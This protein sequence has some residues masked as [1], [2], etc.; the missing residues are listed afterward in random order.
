MARS[1]A[2]AELPP[3]LQGEHP[4]GIRVRAL[5]RRLQFRTDADAGGTGSHE[6]HLDVRNHGP[7]P[8]PEASAAQSRP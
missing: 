7:R 8:R 2:Q 3:A 1:S 6:R 5:L 4:L